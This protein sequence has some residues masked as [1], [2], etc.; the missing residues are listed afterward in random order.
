MRMSSTWGSERDAPGG[1]RLA[2]SDA[3]ECRHARHQQ[4]FAASP[5]LLAPR[6]EEVTHTVQECA[7]S[8][9]HADAR[10][11][12]PSAP[13]KALES[14]FEPD[15][16]DEAATAPAARPLHARLS[17]DECPYVG[18]RACIPGLM[19]SAS[20]ERPAVGRGLD[21]SGGTAFSI[22]P[23]QS[24]AGA[25]GRLPLSRWARPI[26]A[27]R[28]CA[29]TGPCTPLA[30]LFIRRWV[31]PCR[32]TRRACSWTPVVHRHSAASHL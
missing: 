18:R 16:R 28:A 12:R 22:K 32:S 20:A 9:V 26:P 25:R 21:A 14:T 17:E 11:R 6:F 13:A 10:L 1:W 23:K 4:Q 3:S 2:K 31:G 5:Q 24:E 15:R 30:R 7:S 29:L 27:R 19:L 8:S